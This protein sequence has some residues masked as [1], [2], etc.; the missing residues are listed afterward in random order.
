MNSRI[1][2]GFGRIL[3]SIANLLPPTQSFINIG[4]RNIRTVAVKMILEHCGEGINVEKNAVFDSSV[5]LGNHS[6][7]GENCI[8]T[9][10]VIIGDNVMMAREVII[11]P[12]NHVISD[13]TV[14][15]NQQ[16]AEPKQP[17]IVEDDVWIGT[18]AII[19]QGVRIGHGSVIA[20]GA[21][22]TKDVPEFAIVGGGTR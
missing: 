4:Q 22:V 3:F 12:G 5:E 16:G 7:I 19:L 17:V 11:N 6:G 14:P 8:L 1:K 20:A 9:N 13:I 18:R 15:M 21:V 2:R 10:K